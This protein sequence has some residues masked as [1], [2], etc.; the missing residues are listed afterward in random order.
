MPKVSIGVPVFNGERYLEDALESLLAQDETDLEVIVADNASTDRTREIAQ[1]FAHS[2]Q[3]VVYR[4]NDRN[5]GAGPNFNEVF[6]HA[7][8]EFFKWAAH[9]DWISSDYISS[10]LRAL[11]NTPSAVLAFGA[12]RSVDEHGAETPLLGFEFSE[13]ELT[14]LASTSEAVRFGTV[15][16]SPFWCYE[17]FGLIRSSALRRTDLHAPYYGSDRALLAQLS[18][19]GAFEK[20]VGPVLYNRDHTRRS[21]RLSNARER[22][23]WQDV[24]K[25]KGLP[26]P[27]VRLAAHYASVAWRTAPPRARLACLSSLLSWMTQRHMIFKFSLDLIELVS[28]STSGKLFEAALNRRMRSS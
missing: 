23:T 27:H 7:R 4:R 19:L 11:E 21:I 16:S 8:G 26:L 1:D 20:V 10:C 15:I 17:V 3:R 5:I 9:D 14:Q 28:P 22:L 18:L 25:R 13:R 6:R 2:D 24:A 12:T